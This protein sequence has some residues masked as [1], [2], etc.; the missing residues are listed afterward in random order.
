MHGK[1]HGKR[2][3]GLAV[4]GAPGSGEV[5][6][7][8]AVH[9]HP[10]DEAIST[11][12][13]LARYSAEGVRT[14]LVTCTNGEQGDDAGGVKPGEGRHDPDE[15]AARRVDELRRSARLLGVSELELLGYRDSGM[16]GWAANRDPGVFCNV[17][18][19]EAAE[20]VAALMHQY[21]PQVVVTYDEDGG[22]GHPDHIQTH[23]VTVAAAESTGIPAKLYYA[24]FPK[25]AFAE[26]R[27]RLQQAGLDVE[28]LGLT[29]DFGT[30]D[31]LVTSVVDV[32]GY[33]VQKREA[34]FAHA[35]QAAN[36]GFFAR[37]PEEVVTEGLSREWFTLRTPG[38]A[39]G[40]DDLFAGLR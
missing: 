12:G 20:K 19:A 11:G 31:E 32:S 3:H 23:R 4:N 34:L 9:A 1:M 30:P 35:S 8:M 38:A 14:V 6:T 22:Y 33:V 27:Q 18:L 37:L 25:S 26:M 29:G 39:V 36:F 17:P 16:D 2:K 7:L 13:T 40:E 24:A 15:V 28:E 21:R 5:L 10:D